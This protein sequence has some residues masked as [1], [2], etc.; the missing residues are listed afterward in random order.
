M[1]DLYFAV[2]KLSLTG[3]RKQAT[4][5][6]GTRGWKEVTSSD[7]GEKVRRQKGNRSRTEEAFNSSDGQKSTR[8]VEKRLS[9]LHEP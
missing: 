4:Q 2:R 1:E 9:R 3:H 7:I 8:E 5:R 6:K